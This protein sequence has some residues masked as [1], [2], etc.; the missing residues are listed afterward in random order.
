MPDISGPV[1]ELARDEECST[2]VESAKASRRNLEGSDGD[3]DLHNFIPYLIE[4]GKSELLIE[5]FRLRF[6]FE[7]SA[8]KAIQQRLLEGAHLDDYRTKLDSVLVEMEQAQQDVL[9][10]RKKRAIRKFVKLD[11][12]FH[13]MIAILA[14]RAEAAKFIRSLGEQHILLLTE[15][16]SSHFMDDTLVDHR[17]II[18]AIFACEK[19]D[20]RL[21]NVLERHVIGGRLQ[22]KLLQ[23]AEDIA[24]KRDASE[25]GRAQGLGGDTMQLTEELIGEYKARLEESLGIQASKTWP[26]MLQEIKGYV[27][28]RPELGIDDL[29]AFFDQCVLRMRCGEDSY[30][31]CCRHTFTDQFERSRVKEELIASSPAFAHVFEMQSQLIKD[32]QNLDVH[33]LN[34]TPSFTH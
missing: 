27:E 29:D 4:H 28:C 17:E 14:G 33:I 7:L 16:F 10:T 8:A 15:K 5:L 9:S 1:D 23:S 32:T 2:I 20:M 19:D 22:R 34:P 21:R 26:S 6:D 31:L 3:T 25:S 18:D 13:S 12:K 11:F 24:S 30:I